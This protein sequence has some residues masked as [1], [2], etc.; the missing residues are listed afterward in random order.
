MARRFITGTWPRASTMTIP[1]LMVSRV[2]CSARPE[3]VDRSRCLIQKPPSRRTAAVA[4]RAVELR[5]LRVCRVVSEHLAHVEADQHDQRI[6]VQAPE[7]DDPVDAVPSA[8][9]PEGPT[10]L[11]R[12]WSKNGRPAM[13][14][15]MTRFQ[16]RSACP[17]NPISANQHH[18]PSPISSVW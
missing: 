10:I 12:A 6:V 2:V 11:D 5:A 15:P 1:W 16:Q 14:A 17:H 8:G 3:A 9:H 18:Q 13:S 7:T 4:I